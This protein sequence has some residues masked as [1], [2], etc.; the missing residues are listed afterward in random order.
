MSVVKRE[1]PTVGSPKEPVVV[2]TEAEQPSL[3]AVG[4][5]PVTERTISRILRPEEDALIGHVRGWCHDEDVCLLCASGES[6]QKLTSALHTSLDLFKE[7]GR[8]Y[9]QLQAMYVRAQREQQDL[10]DVIDRIKEERDDYKAER[11]VLVHYVN[12]LED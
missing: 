3:F 2:T 11:D 4:P 10:C 7:K 8:S 6:A 9:R 12:G 5:T 1:D